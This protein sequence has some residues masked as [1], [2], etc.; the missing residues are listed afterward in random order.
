T[1]HAM[2]ALKER[3]NEPV[4]VVRDGATVEV[5]ANELVAGD[6]LELQPGDAVPVDARVLDASALQVDESTLTG[7]SLPVDKLPD[8]TPDPSLP[9]RRSM[10]YAGSDVVAGSGRGVVVATGSAT[11]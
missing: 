3:T 2:D 9:E 6:L 7:E 8:P 11:E 1:E 5:R 4:S 10:V